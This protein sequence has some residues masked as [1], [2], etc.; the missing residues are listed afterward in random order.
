MRVNKL[1]LEKIDIMIDFAIARVSDG[2][3][4]PRIAVAELARRWPDATGLQ[5]IFVLVSAAHAIEEVFAGDEREHY[6]VGM[7]LR[8]AA[9][10]GTDLF[11]LQQRGNFAPTGRQL[12]QYWAE[13][14]GY[15]LAT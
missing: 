11:A 13:F 4:G 9:L 15:F 8:M 2:A 12:L 14:D 7:T 3:Q 6:E 10:L 5:L 1:G